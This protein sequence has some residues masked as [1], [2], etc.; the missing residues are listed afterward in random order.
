[1]LEFKARTNLKLKVSNRQMAILTGCLLGDGYI[2]PRGQIQIEQGIKQLPYLLWKY[3]NLRS[4]AYGPPKIIKRFDKRYKQEYVGA[5]FWLRQYFRPLRRM[6]YPKGKK[7]VPLEIAGYI[8]KLSLAIWYMDDGNLYKGR[9]VKIATDGFDCKSRR[10]V[11]EILFSK[12]GIESTIH[13]NGKLR[14]SSSSL[15]RFFNLIKN[16]IHSSMTYKI[17]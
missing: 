12:F 1:M 4:L 10:I 3:K 2:H 7:V 9:N 5:R 13:K 16:H 8:T 6:F 14:I 15:E 11:K 17:P